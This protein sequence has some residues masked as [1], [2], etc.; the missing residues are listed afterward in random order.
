[1]G[2]QESCCRRSIRTAEVELT[3]RLLNVRGDCVI[4]NELKVGVGAQTVFCC[5]SKPHM[6]YC[7][8]M[9]LM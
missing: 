5:D 4:G 2:S 1:M 3:F 8:C 9:R 6:L 7:D